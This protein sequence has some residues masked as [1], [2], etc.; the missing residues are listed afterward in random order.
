MRLYSG[1]YDISAEHS[2]PNWFIGPADDALLHRMPD[3]N[4]FTGY[5]GVETNVD[6][7]GTC[8]DAGGNG[9]DPRRLPGW[10]VYDPHTGAVNRN[11]GGRDI[12][13]YPEGCSSTDVRMPSETRLSNIFSPPWP[14]S[15]AEGD[16]YGGCYEPR[17][18]YS[19]V[20]RLPQGR[21]RLWH[22]LL[23]KT[24]G[25]VIGWDGEGWIDIPGVVDR[26]YP[27]VF[28]NRIGGALNTDIDPLA[29]DFTRQPGKSNASPLRSCP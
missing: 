25:G 5:T 8:T 26:V 7:A 4:Q 21:H 2:I 18:L 16:N 1:D 27:R 14:V 6:D 12:E 20:V 3:E 29:E 13:V 24:Q 15:G 9:C 22:G 19:H 23:I 10:G 11:Q 17:K 28:D